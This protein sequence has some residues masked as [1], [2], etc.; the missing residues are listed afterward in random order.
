[1]KCNFC[2]D[3]MTSVYV[4]DPNN[5]SKVKKNIGF[6]CLRCDTIRASNDYLQKIKRDIEDSD[7]HEQAR[8]KFNEYSKPEKCPKCKGKSF[9][10][11]ASKVPTW[12]SYENSD[13][14]KNWQ[15]NNPSIR[16]ECKKCRKYSSSISLP[17]PYPLP[18][19]Y[20]NPPKS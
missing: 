19:K 1:M 10:E 17:M 18:K 9:E 11:I 3:Y 12:T 15:L 4:N 20:R 13:G 6:M 8:P 5:E 2:H 7:Q 16:F 14:S